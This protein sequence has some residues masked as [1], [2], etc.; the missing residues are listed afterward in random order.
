MTAYLRHQHY[1]RQ[2]GPLS[3]RG[4]HGAHAQTIIDFDHDHRDGCAHYIRG[5]SGA[6][7][8]QVGG[9]LFISVAPALFSS[10]LCVPDCI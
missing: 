1:S 3:K 7:D 6:R 10:L 2:S 5:G 8:F 4:Q 9:L